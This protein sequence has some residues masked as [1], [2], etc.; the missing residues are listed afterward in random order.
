MSGVALFLG[1]P[2]DKARTPAVFDAWAAATGTP[3]RMVALSLP[4]AALADTLAA[5]R[6]WENALGAVVTFPHK[7]AAFACLDAADDTARFTG[8]CNVIR[9]SPDGR[10]I[11]AMTDGIG[12]IGAAAGGGARLA[13]ADMVL[14]GAGGAGAAIAH[15]AARRG[16]ARLVIRDLD[17]ARAGDLRRR[18]AAAFPALALPETVPQGFGHDILCNATPLGM[19]GETELP[20]RLDGCHA[21]SLVIDVVPS[22]AMTPFLQAAAA[23]GL[24]V[25]TGPEM[26]AGQFRHVAAHLLGCDA[27]TL[28][29]A[30]DRGL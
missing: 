30:N 27:A 11:G 26:V 21:G 8:A 24:R 29:A 12:C 2:V 7:Q 22:P 14:V 23:R 20:H 15:E 3:A 9:R 10:L 19:D 4:P 18:L 6:G 28:P 16:V 17:A 1:Q 25:Q 13:G 5:L